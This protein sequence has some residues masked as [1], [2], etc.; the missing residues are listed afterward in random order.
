MRIKFLQSV[1]A[2]AWAYLPNEVHD[3]PDDQAAQYIANDVAVRMVEI[4][5][6]EAA[7]GQP[8]RSLR[9]PTRGVPNA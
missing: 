7:P 8:A 3:V 5:A 6:T 1:A 9:Q 4:E 2:T